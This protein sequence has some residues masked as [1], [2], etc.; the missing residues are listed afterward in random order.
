[1]V[2]SEENSAHRSNET[3][4]QVS[5]TTKTIAVEQRLLAPVIEEISAAWWELRRRYTM[6][7]RGHRLGTRDRT[8]RFFTRRGLERAHQAYLD[9]HRRVYRYWYQDIPIT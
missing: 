8:L 5:D 6:T 2:S 9:A 3:S 4:P 7:V 1:M